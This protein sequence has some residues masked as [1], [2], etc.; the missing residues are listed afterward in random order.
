M[1]LKERN[2]IKDKERIKQFLENT[3]RKLC[4]DMSDNDNLGV[5]ATK[6]ATDIMLKLSNSYKNMG[7]DKNVD[8]DKIV[9]ALKTDSSVKL[10]GSGNSNNYL[11][12]LERAIEIVKA[13]GNS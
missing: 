12:S 11:I 7:F 6:E 5:T 4:D 10:Y 1:T 3:M 8:K 9:E 2:E 13:G